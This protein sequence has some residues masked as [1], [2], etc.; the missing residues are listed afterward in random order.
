MPHIL[1]PEFELRQ[2]SC[3]EA[4]GRDGIDCLIMLPGTNFRYFTGI[5]FARERHRLLCAVMTREGE[6][7]LM[8]TVFEEDK[9]SS[10]PTAAT[11]ETWTD[12]EDQ[13]GR[14]AA[15]LRERFGQ[16][17]V[18]ALEQTTNYYHYLDLRAAMPEATFADPVCAT[19]RIRAI[20]SDAEIA[21]FEEACARTRARMERVPSQLTEGMTE[22]DLVTL[23]GPSAMI[24]FGLT[25]S[26][27]NETAG[28]R[29]LAEGDCIVIDAGDR[30]E[31]YRSDLT[32]TFF[33]GEPS[34]RMREVY[35]T[36]NEAELAAID[37]A[38]PGAPAEVV[39]LAAREVIGKAGFGEFFTHRGGH[40]LGLDF[41]EIPLCV[42]GNEEPLEP[43]MVLTAEPG[44][45]LPGEFGMRLEDDL[46][47]TE[48]GCRL[49]S[50]R[51][52]LYLD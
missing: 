3:V 18:L 38:R 11:V 40:G 44:I 27:P 45:Y 43:G 21:C 8:G 7:A 32:R 15:F 16:S 14:V 13:W 33:F 41:H 26:M 37:A 25:T 49:L 19:D 35:R 5:K 36:V 23:Y 24:Q 51:G 50:R 52:P 46:L 34:A 20:K 47:I 28:A 39:D 12:E 31:G 6:L 2:R 30:V 1:P 10:G 48:D 22:R 42:A 4:M 29:R 9:M 17:P